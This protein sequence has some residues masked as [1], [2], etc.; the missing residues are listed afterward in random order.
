VAI[1]SAPASELSAEKSVGAHFLRANRMPTASMEVAAMALTAT[2][3]SSK[4]CA[5]DCEAEGG[6]V[7]TA[8]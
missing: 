1:A 2:A 5:G 8:G 4:R 3:A 7:L 6:E